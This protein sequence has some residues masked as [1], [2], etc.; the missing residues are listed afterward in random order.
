[1]KRIFVDA[2]ILVDFFDRNAE[3]HNISTLMMNILLNEYKVL[4]T[5]TSF[6]ITYYLASKNRIEKDKANY[7]IKA[8]FSVFNFIKEDQSIMNKVF[9]SKFNDLED[10]L[11]YFAAE[12]AGADCIV[13]KNVHDFYPARIPVMHPLVFLEDHYL[14]KGN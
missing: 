10:A 9:K 4:V 3:E 7:H 13:T 6:A 2:N 11:Q 14:R 1:M 8:V 5:P 12:E